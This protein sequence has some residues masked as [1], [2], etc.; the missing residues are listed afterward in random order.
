MKKEI[1]QI[2][3]KKNYLLGK[4][5]KGTK[6]WLL[7]PSWDCDWYWGFGWIETY[8][9]SEELE[10]HSHAD[11]FMSEYFTKWNGNNPILKEQTFNKEEGWELSELFSQFYHLR[12]Q[13]EFWGRGK[14]YVADTEIKNWKDKKLADE[15]NKKMIPVITKRITDILT[16]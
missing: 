8:S 5:K 14:R 7:T 6:H 4:D 10:S 2:D 13:A 3:D 15:I 11:N 12:E 16:P 9:K 1:K